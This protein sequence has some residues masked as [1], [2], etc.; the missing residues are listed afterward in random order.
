MTRDDIKLIAEQALE[1]YNKEYLPTWDPM[2]KWGQPVYTIIRINTSAGD[3]NSCMGEIYA[4]VVPA[5]ANM[6][7]TLETGR[8]VCVLQP[9]PESKITDFLGSYGVGKT[10]WVELISVQ[11]SSITDI[12]KE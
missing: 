4:V 9:C 1:I 3:A 7:T 6:Q 11:G 12:K 10:T 8:Q 5:R 2:L